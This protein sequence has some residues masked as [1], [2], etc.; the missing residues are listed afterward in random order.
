MEDLVA[1]LTDKEID[2]KVEEFL[3]TLRTRFLNIDPNEYYLSYSGG[4]DS[5]LIYWFIKEIMHD[6]K[7]EIVG[8]NT[9]MEHPEILKRIM[10]YSD[11]V[12]RPALKPFDIKKKYGIPCFSKQQ[13]FFIYYYQNALRK[14]KKPSPSIIKRITGGRES[15]FN[16]SKKAREYVLGDNP[17]NITHLC[18]YYLK[19]K[20]FH[21]FEK[22]TGKK[23]I[24]GIRGEESLMRKA[25]Y[26]SCFAKDGTFT[27]LHDC[28]EW[29]EEAIMKK[30]N[31]EIPS[32]YEHVTRSG[33]FLP[34]VEIATN[35][36]FK[37][38]DELDG[39]EKILSVDDSGNKIF[40][41]YKKVELDYDGELVKVKLQTLET[42]TTPDHKFMGYNRDKKKLDIS[43]ADS[44]SRISIP[45]N[46]RYTDNEKTDLTSKEKIL[47]AT[48]ADG[49]LAKGYKDYTYEFHLK[50]DRK[51]KRLTELLKDSGYKYYTNM[52]KD[53]TV[54]IMAVLDR[55]SKDL[56]KCFDIN[57]IST[58]KAKDIIRE[59]V[60]WDGH[61]DKN[62]RMNYTSNDL[63]QIN[64]YA[65]ISAIAGYSHYIYKAKNRK[66]YNL[67]IYTEKNRNYKQQKKETK[68]YKGKVHCV[69]IGDNLC[70]FRANNKTF[71]AYNCM[72]CP[73]GS[74]F[75]EVEKELGIISDSQRRFCTTLFHESFDVLG[76]KYNPEDIK[77]DLY[78]GNKHE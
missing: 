16:L 68:Y 5:H 10:K 56:R 18:C 1:Q 66:T 14:G 28:P 67:I 61:V 20:P 74:H 9:Y 44:M 45:A 24:L 8:C 35:H 29:L 34:D 69:D 50:K 46:M 43:T 2:N 58:Y 4:K 54:K 41:D 78:G 39:S 17:H 57:A 33:C 52:K 22:A 32:I 40:R 6:D 63:N 42:W 19:K 27:P 60:Q 71:V 59:M 15:Y 13:D 3:E 76:V 12:L 62:N 25:Q 11:R 7:I 49:C 47:I 73:Y 26:K 36:G 31:I 53:G 72:C 37:R 64:F 65:I 21:D 51:I 30:Y 70:L 77:E 23:P 75:G 48:Q 38:L 55:P